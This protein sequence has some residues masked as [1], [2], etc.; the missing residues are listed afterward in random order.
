MKR[1]RVKIFVSVLVMLASVSVYAESIDKINANTGKPELVSAPNT[2]VLY[3]YWASSDGKTNATM[4][5]YKGTYRGMEYNYVSIDWNDT[6]G[7][8]VGIGKQVATGTESINY[9]GY[10]VPS[11]AGCYGPYGWMHLTTGTDKL[12]EYYVCEGVG[13]KFGPHNNN[14]DGDYPTKVGYSYSSD[15]YTYQAYKHK[16]VGQPSIEGNSTNFWQY[17]SVRTNYPVQPIPGTI[18]G[19]VTL[20]NH[21]QQWKTADKKDFNNYKYLILAIES[22]RK[23]V[24]SNVGYGFYYFGN[25]PIK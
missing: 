8:V 17:I 16:R 2:K 12:V 11:E 13:T 19:T 22:W 24:N 21:I 20:A 6:N 18:Q 15:G 5:I 10:Y 14:N 25:G 3:N 23:G 7:F 4:T 1:L 9:N